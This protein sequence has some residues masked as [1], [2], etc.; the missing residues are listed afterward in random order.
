MNDTGL[1]LVGLGIGAVAFVVL[2]AKL[3]P[4]VRQRCPR[5][6]AFFSRVDASNH[7]VT[8]HSTSES[9]DH[10]TGERREV[11]S[12]TAGNLVVRRC[13]KCDATWERLETS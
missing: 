3:V 11:H 13:R 8:V 5:C 4:L 1:L 12:R 2:L 10:R 7:I 6:G 9:Y